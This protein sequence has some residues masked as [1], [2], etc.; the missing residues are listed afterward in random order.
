MPSVIIIVLSSWILWFRSLEGWN[1]AGCS[2]T[3]LIGLEWPEV[4][5]S[6]PSVARAWAGEMPGAGLSE[7]CCL[8]CFYVVLPQPGGSSQH[9]SCLEILLL[10]GWSQS[11]REGCHL[12]LMTS[13]GAHSVVLALI[14]Q[15]Q[16]WL[17][18]QPCYQEGH[19]P[20]MPQADPH[21]WRIREINKWDLLFFFYSY[22]LWTTKISFDIKWIGARIVLCH[23][24]LNMD[25]LAHWLELSSMCCYWLVRECHCMQALRARLP[26][27]IKESLQMTLLGH[28]ARF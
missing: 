16:H 7:V 4:K 10:L 15:V 28:L 2:P 21:M 19:H 13:L 5:S 17:Q 11:S 12:A 27:R 6:S 9:G 24:Q 26:S 1:W 8:P 14:S 25:I 20:L 3:R 18:G 23:N 22:C